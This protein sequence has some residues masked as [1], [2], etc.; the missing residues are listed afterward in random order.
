M[1]FTYKLCVLLLQ[2]LG[3]DEPVHERSQLSFPVIYHTQPSPS[4]QQQQQMVVVHSTQ[5]KRHYAQQAQAG[6]GSMA[7]T[8]TAT[9][10]N[11][12]GGI[13]SGAPKG[14]SKT[15]KEIISAVLSGQQMIQIEKL[16]SACQSS[17]V[18]DTYL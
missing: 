11:E 16:N 7:V 17:G 9:T 10:E 18:S 12:G 1:Q 4:P 2:V 14:M 13:G 8:T 15:K 5:K 3:A 6:G